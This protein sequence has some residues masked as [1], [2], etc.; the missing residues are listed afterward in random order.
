MGNNGSKPTDVEQIDISNPQAKG[1]E[2]DVQKSKKHYTISPDG[3]I[4]FTFSHFNQ[5]YEAVSKAIENFKNLLKLETPMELSALLFKLDKIK[6]CAVGE[7]YSKELDGLISSTKNDFEGFY[8]FFKDLFLKDKSM[9]IESQKYIDQWLKGIETQTVSI[10]SEV[11]KEADA[12]KEILDI[13]DNF[14]KFKNQ[15]ASIH[16]ILSV[17]KFENEKISE[18]YDK[19][20]EY[21][22]NNKDSFKDSFTFEDFQTFRSFINSLEQLR[23]FLNSKNALISKFTDVVSALNDLYSDVLKKLNSSSDSF[24]VMGEL[25]EYF[26]LM[27]K[28][29]YIKHIELKIKEIEDLVNSS[30]KL[31]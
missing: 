16:K 1:L 25:N 15:F 10:M 3:T 2:L 9:Y 24:E 27:I 31:V 8:S 14:H 18:N 26:H 19:I 20:N 30:N 6:Q 12:T 23:S 7:E 5:K 29:R 4:K 21:F 17:F 11:K 28:H 22:T 13:A